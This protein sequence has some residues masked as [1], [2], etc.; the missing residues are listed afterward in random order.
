MAASALAVAGSH[1][2]ILDAHEGG[3]T[4]IPNRV[5]SPPEWQY[6]HPRYGLN[7]HWHVALGWQYMGAAHAATPIRLKLEGT[8]RWG[9][10]TSARHG[11][12]WL[13][14]GSGSSGAAYDHEYPE[15][16]VG[17]PGSGYSYA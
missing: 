13:C 12:H 10:G 11:V 2:P 14:D 15:G 9:L 5:R 3:W 6:G 8:R 7:R 17:S 16:H 4:R 1:A